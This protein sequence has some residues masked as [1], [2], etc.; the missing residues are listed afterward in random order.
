MNKQEVLKELENKKCTEPSDS[1][2]YKWNEALDSAIETVKQLTEPEKPLLSRTEAEW[3]EELKEEEIKHSFY[4]KYDLLY[5]IT[6]FGFGHGFSFEVENGKYIQLYE[7]GKDVKRRLVNA[8]LF[9]Y[10]VEK[11][12]PSKSKINKFKL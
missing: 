10:T 1:S 11:L 3:L 12:P 9:G 8:L 7:Y 4:K 6:R 5:Y 2:D